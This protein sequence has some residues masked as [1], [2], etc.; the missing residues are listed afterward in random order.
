MEIFKYPACP[1]GQP[2]GTVPRNFNPVPM[3]R[4]TSVPVPVPR[5]TKSAGTDWESRP[6]GWS[7]ETRHKPKLN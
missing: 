3:V 2:C 5:D 6:A 4:N 7:C 1:V